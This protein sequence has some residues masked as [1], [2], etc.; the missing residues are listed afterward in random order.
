M[1]YRGIVVNWNNTSFSVQSTAILWHRLLHMTRVD[2]LNAVQHFNVINI[3]YMISQQT[4]DV[5][6]MFV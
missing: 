6:P 3:G 1:Q 5:D 4:E 2:K